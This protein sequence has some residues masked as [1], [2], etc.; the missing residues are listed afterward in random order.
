[1]AKTVIVGRVTQAP[2]QPVGTE[3]VVVTVAEDDGYYPKDGGDYVEC[4]N[5][6]DVCFFNDYHK[7][8]LMDKVR[9]G[10]LIKVDATLRVR[11]REVGGKNIT[12]NTLLGDKVQ[13]LS[14][15][16]KNRTERQP[17]GEDQNMPAQEGDGY[18]FAA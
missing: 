11:K 9:K 12:V 16:Q 4:P 6:F 15:A 7:K 8:K 13:L 18:D 1:M 10:D 2:K 5:F 3:M 14:Q 17:A